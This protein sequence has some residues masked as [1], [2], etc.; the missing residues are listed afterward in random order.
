MWI[1]SEDKLRELSPRHVRQYYDRTLRYFL[2]V[3]WRFKGRHRGT[4]WQWDGRASCR[5]DID[6]LKAIRAMLRTGYKRK[7]P[8]RNSPGACAI[9]RE[10]ETGRKRPAKTERSDWRW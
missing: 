2:T 5:R 3:A 7:V 1:R 9:D 8:D 4:S 10:D 6:R